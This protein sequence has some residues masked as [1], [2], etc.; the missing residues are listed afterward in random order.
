MPAPR[1]IVV[2]ESQRQ[3]MFDWCKEKAPEEACGLV[4][5][6]DG[7]AVKIYRAT[8]VEPVDKRIRYAIDPAELLTVFKQIDDEDL[9]FLGIFHSHVKSQAYPSATDIRLSYYPEAIYFMISLQHPDPELRA[10]V[11][12]KP[13]ISSDQGHPVEITLVVEPEP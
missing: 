3:E 9:D 6:R 12:E 1:R 10:F 8:N 11:I 7:R 2:T 4:A 13:D 5:G